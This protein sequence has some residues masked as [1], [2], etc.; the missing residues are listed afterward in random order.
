[1]G[2]MG[3]LGDD[4]NRDGTPYAYRT[5]TIIHFNLSQTKVKIHFNF[6]KVYMP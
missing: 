3:T 5:K 2:T 6:G 1:M 4:G